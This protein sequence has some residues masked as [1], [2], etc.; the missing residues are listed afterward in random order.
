MSKTRNSE[1][2]NRMKEKKGQKQYLKNNGQKL[3]KT[4]ESHPTTD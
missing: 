1:I 3:F 4:D 2:V